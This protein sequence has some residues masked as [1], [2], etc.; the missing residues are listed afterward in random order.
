METPAP[1]F[2]PA[3]AA[4]APALADLINRAYRS[5]ASQAG[6]TTEGHLLDG[7]RVDEETLRTMLAAPAAVLLK[8][9]LSGQLAGCVYLENQGKYLYLSM[10]A[11]APEAQAHG[12]GRQLLGAAE[13]HARQLGC[14][15]IQMSVLELRPEL[16][17]WYE[18]QGYRRTGA[19]EPFPATT[20]FGR[21]RQPLTLL[22]LEKAIANG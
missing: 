3:T 16:L 12:L 1:T 11:V 10:L 14:A 15:S 19:S 8:A 6:W 4:D 9:E 22:A 13:A 20:R 7:P 18:R 2:S 17:A 21:P 5:E